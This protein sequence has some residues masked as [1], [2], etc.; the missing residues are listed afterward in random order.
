MPR[1]PRIFVAG[2]TYHVY[3]RVARGERPFVDETVA[4]AFVSMLADVKREHGLTVL[5][6]CLMPNHYHLVL[7]AGIG[8]RYP[9]ESILW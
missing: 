4:G 2:G 3:C 1:K 9:I 7:R 5:A 6:W 8:T